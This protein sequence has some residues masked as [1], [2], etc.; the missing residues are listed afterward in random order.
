MVIK[1][2]V[3]LALATLGIVLPLTGTLGVRAAETATPTS[4]AKV[5]VKVKPGEFTFKQQ[6]SQAMVPSF[7]FSDAQV[8]NENQQLELS[9]K[10]NEKISVNNYS[11]TGEAWQVNAKLSALSLTNDNKKDATI[12]GAYISMTPSQTSNVASPKTITPQEF[13]AGAE[14]TPLLKFDK[15]EGMGSIEF[16]LTNVTLNLPKITW[17]GSY[18][19]DLTYTLTKTPTN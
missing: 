8:S 12:S 17:Q 11:G 18:T 9:N 4:G 3:F 2:K 5:N 6:D 13:T 16:S 14:S 7:S 10:A 15:N 1:A 19:A